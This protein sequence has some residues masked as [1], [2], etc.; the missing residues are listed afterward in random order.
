MDM[1]LPV[2]DTSERRMAGKGMM[3][4]T[5]KVLKE[6]LAGVPDDYELGMVISEKADGMVRWKEAR[7]HIDK[8]MHEYMGRAEYI[9]VFNE[10]KI[11]L[12]ISK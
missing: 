9:D 3:K 1:A 7:K 5:V 2:E 8:D 12:F 10:H 4:V 6:V 11:V